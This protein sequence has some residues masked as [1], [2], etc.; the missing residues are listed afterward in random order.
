MREVGAQDGQALRNSNWVGDINFW[1]EESKLI[2]RYN[3]DGT[4][5]N[6]SRHK[7]AENEQLIG[8]YGVKGIKESFSSFGFLVKV[9]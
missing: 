9:R 6:L 7:L 3:P 1:D 2:S 5:L 4:N 8:V